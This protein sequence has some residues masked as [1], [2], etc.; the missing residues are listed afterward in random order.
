VQTIEI[1]RAFKAIGYKPKRTIRFVLFAMKKMVYA[2]ATNMQKK[3]KQ[4][5]RNTFLL[6][7]VMPVVFTPRAFGLR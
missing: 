6:W 5:M 3:Q 7:K 2:A 1:L 4:K